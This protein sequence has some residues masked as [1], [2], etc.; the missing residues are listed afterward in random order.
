MRVSR[1]TCVLAPVFGE[2][3]SRAT[4]KTTQV[5]QI[6]LL[7]CGDRLREEEKQLNTD[8]ELTPRTTVKSPK[9]SIVNIH[10]S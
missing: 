8:T 7:S 1:L 9:M 10:H 5:T 2:G 3:V 4:G 6:R